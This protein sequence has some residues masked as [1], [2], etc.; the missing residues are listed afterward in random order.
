MPHMFVCLSCMYVCLSY[1]Y[2]CLSCTEV[3]RLDM[4]N[5]CNVN[6]LKSSWKIVFVTNMAVY[7][8][9]TGLVWDKISNQ[10]PNMPILVYKSDN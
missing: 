7:A 3:Q 10:L 1:M 5:Y 2:V 8:Y 4:V 9:R 6:R